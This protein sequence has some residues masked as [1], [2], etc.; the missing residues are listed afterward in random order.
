VRLTGGDRDPA[1]MRRCLAAQARHAIAAGVDQI[2]VREHDLEAADL[3]AI[4]AELVALARGSRTRILVNDRLDV[5]LACGAAGV[6]LRTDSMPAAAAR[7]ICPPGFIVGV[8]VHSVADAEAAA[9]G[10]DYL[11]AGTVWPT[12][13]KS[14]GHDCIDVDGLTRIVSAVRIPV[15]AIGGVTVARLPLAARAGA[16]GIAAIGMFMASAAENEA[17]CRARSL[18][19]VVAAAR[20][21]FDTPISG[22]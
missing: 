11:T 22:S 15:L 19:E 17:G 12:Q 6:H 14:A 5:A 2:Q 20:G 1:A 16:R 9:A 3:A 4:V 21:A 8:S 18:Q 13:S 10:A 7:R